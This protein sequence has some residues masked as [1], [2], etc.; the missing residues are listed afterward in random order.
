MEYFTIP[1]LSLTATT[2]PGAIDLLSA[3][4]AYDVCLT[5]LEVRAKNLSINIATLV[6]FHHADKQFFISNIAN[7]TIIPH[8]ITPQPR[9]VTR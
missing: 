1:P 4:P 5:I 2:E 3:K 8:T 7:N 6:N 9:Q